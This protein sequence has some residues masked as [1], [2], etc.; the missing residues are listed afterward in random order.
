MSVPEIQAVRADALALSELDRA[1]L[2]RDLVASLDGPADPN[3]AA[4]WDMELCRRINQIESG[5]AKLL[6]VDEVLASARKRLAGA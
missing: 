2:A 5:E 1:T 3:V 6:D 4:A